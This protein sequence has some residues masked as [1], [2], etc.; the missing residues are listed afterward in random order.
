[1]KLR[2]FK[3]KIFWAVCSPDGYVQVRSLAEK[4]KDAK[5]QIRRDPYSV[6]WKDYE[7]EGFFLVKIVVSIKA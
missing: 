1:M 4:Q 2:E 3:N 5:E 6:S 7:K